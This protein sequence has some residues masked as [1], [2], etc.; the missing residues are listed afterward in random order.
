MDLDRTFPTMGLAVNKKNIK[1]K[2]FDSISG[3]KDK[4]MKLHITDENII[5]ALEKVG[6]NNL[7]LI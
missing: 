7:V 5:N 6:A 4:K 2:I 3:D 1:E